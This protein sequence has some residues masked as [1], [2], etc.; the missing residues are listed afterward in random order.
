LINSTAIGQN[1]SWR[2]VAG[3]WI[4]K[5]GTRHDHEWFI[6]DR[7]IPGRP[8]VAPDWIKEDPYFATCLGSGTIR[9]VISAD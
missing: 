4:D 1:P 6:A 9:E 8:T 2:P 3:G 7:S 5:S